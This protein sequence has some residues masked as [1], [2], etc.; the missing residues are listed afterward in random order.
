MYRY[1][2]LLEYNTRNKDVNVVFADD[3]L[4]KKFIYKPDIPNNFNMNESI[5]DFIHTNVKNIIG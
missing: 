5:L 4:L 1:T 2:D 3:N